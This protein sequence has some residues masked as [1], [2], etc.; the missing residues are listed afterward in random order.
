V[1]GGLGI[2]LYLT[3][4]VYWVVLGGL[5]DNR[6]VNFNCFLGDGF[7]LASLKSIFVISYYKS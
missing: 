7:S 4:L 6:S 3:A 1:Q 2:P 5:V